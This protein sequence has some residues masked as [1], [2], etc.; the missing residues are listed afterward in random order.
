[1]SSKKIASNESIEVHAR[2]VLLT[3]LI[4]VLTIG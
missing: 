2:Y 3:C 4:T 1:M